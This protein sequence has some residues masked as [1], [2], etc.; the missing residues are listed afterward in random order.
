M[1]KILDKYILVRFARALL[2]VTLA[3]LILIIAINMVEELKDFVDNDVPFSDIATYYIYFSGWALKSFLPVF[4]FLAGLFTVGSLARTN[5]LRAIRAGGVSLYRVAAP[6]IISA[7]LI[8]AAHFYYNEYV[9]PPANRR[10]VELKEFTIEKRS[11][12]SI[13]N[14]Y[15][16]YRQISDSAYYVV[17]KYSIPEKT[18]YGVKLYRRTRNRLGEFI[19]A[20][21]MKL[22]RGSWTFIDGF[23][24]V[25]DSSGEKTVSSFDTLPAPII[26]DRPADFE[27]RLG[28]P[29]DM[30]YRELKEYIS[31]MKRTGG[32][33]E[34]ELVD[35]KVKLSFPLASVV[36]MV[37][38]IPLAANRRQAGVAGPLASAAG[39]ILVYFVA[40]K[41]TKAL[42]AHSYIPT[43]LAA[44][45]VNGA[46]LLVGLVMLVVS[47][48]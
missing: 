47:R 14:R 16:M 44:W 37:L 42:G 40:F 48:K 26:R 9:F 15:H 29:E 41:V 43:D 34:Q 46:F 17:D 6:L 24:H 25:F 35:L 2:V 28:K 31:L 23:R 39:L 38:C 32:P 21:S 19:T 22:N 5:E 45:S 7:A 36:V 10:L 30:G 3:V 18:G 8:S 13:I 11:R 20:A 33:Y 12:A 1:I 4:V 27:R